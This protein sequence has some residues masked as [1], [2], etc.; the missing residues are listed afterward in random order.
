M[1]HGKTEI[2]LQVWNG[3]GWNTQGPY[4]DS[5]EAKRLFMQQKAIMPNCPCKLIKVNTIR[6][7]RLTEVAPATSSISQPHGT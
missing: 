3:E 5:I 7:H 1:S 4:Y 2:Y 6:G